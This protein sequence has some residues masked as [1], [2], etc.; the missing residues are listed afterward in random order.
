M[1]LKGLWPEGA[2]SWDEGPQ[3]G[4]LSRLRARGGGP[5]FAR[6][7][8]S[9]CG[10]GEGDSIP[11]SRAGACL[12]SAKRGTR[13]FACRQAGSAPAGSRRAGA[14]PSRPLAPQGRRPYWRRVSE[15][16]QPPARS[17]LEGLEG[18]GCYPAGSRS[19]GRARARRARRSSGVIART[20]SAV[21]GGV[22]LATGCTG[23]P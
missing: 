12:S 20:S 14:P 15:R 10:A 22:V 3:S 16:A 19:A 2:G 11:G 1:A 4:F 23:L 17:P 8:A 18:T 21:L 5:P 6:T 7:R 9:A 13:R